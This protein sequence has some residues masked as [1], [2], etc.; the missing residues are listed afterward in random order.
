MALA[1]FVKYQIKE[2]L[3]VRKTDNKSDTI[4]FQ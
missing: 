3:I 4:V 2:Y 1:P